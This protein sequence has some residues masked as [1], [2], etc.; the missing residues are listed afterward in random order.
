MLKMPKLFTYS[1]LLE[2]W[3][4]QNHGQVSFQMLSIINMI[5]GKSLRKCKIVQPHS[6]NGDNYTLCRVLI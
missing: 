4:A 5:V 1:E 2:G 6:L 3:L